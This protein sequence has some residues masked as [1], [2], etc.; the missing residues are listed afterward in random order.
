MPDHVEVGKVFAFIY[1]FLYVVFSK[2]ALA[3]GVGVAH[4]AYWLALAH[5]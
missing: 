2:M 3:S 5:C 4:S 1:R